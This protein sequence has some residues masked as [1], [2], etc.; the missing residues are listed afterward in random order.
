MSVTTEDVRRVAALARLDLSAEE[1]AKLT[2][3]L[4]RILQYMEKLNELD[5]DGVSPSAH[6]IPV[7]GTF[8]ADEPELFAD[9]AALLAQAPDQRD[10]YYRVPRV[11]D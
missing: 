3:E 9:L 2:Q 4:G 1:E 5:T 11:L 6:P 10:G 7:S 8:R